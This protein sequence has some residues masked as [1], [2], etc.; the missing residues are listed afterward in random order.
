M[1]PFDPRYTISFSIYIKKP[2]PPKLEILKGNRFFKA[3]LKTLYKLKNFS[4][5]IIKAILKD[6][7]LLIFMRYEV[8]F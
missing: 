3:P 2:I 6:F 8:G 4:R 1:P 7:L 5:F